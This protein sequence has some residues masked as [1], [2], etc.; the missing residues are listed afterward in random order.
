MTVNGPLDPAQLGHTLMH[1]HIFIDFN[2]PDDDAERW[3]IAGRTKPLGVTAVRLYDAPVTMDILGDLDLGAPN[4][5]NWL[6]NNEKTAIAEVSEYKLH[7]GNTIVDVTSI[8]LKRNPEGLRRVSQASGLNIV[9]GASWYTQAW[10]PKSLDSRSIEDLTAEIVNDV[11]VGVA[12]TNIRSGIIGE[13]GTSANPTVGNEAKIIRASARASRLTGAAITLHS[14]GRL[15]QHT[16]ILN[17]LAEE[18]ADLSRVVMGHSDFLTGELD[19]IKPL[20]DRGAT[21]E[22]DLLGKPPLITRGRPV[23][24]EVAKTIAD[25]VKAGYADHIVMS[26]DICR[27]TSL[28][29][30]GGTG[31]SFTEEAFLPYLKTLGVTAA[32]INTMVVENPRRLLTFVAPQSPKAMAAKTGGTK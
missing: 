18:G 27:K 10:Y 31:Y 4:H 9:M 28:K 22:F 32:Q 5:D 1:E 23:D 26:Q 8:G 15:K 14:I 13:V 29:T 7:G 6:L 20:L 25:L 17:M 11:T 2:V 19:Y 21:I 30:Y 16:T 3:R 24:A 12:D